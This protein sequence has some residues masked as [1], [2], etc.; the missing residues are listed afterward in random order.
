MPLFA[1]PLAPSSTTQHAESKTTRVKFSNL[2]LRKRK[3]PQATEESSGDENSSLDGDAAGPA[4]TNPLS[5]TP[6]E[7]AQYQLAGLELDEELPDVK[8]FP[9]RPVPQSFESRHKKGRRRERSNARNT[10]IDEEQIIAEEEQEEGKVERISR[11]PWL[12]NQHLSVLVTILH[13]CLGE[14]DIQRASRAWALLLRTQIS[15]RGVD[16][17][18][19]G[20]WE[21][22]AAL[23][24]RSR[25]QKKKYSYDD[26]ERDE[27]DEHVEEDMGVERRWGS[28]EGLELVK[29]YYERLILEFPYNRQFQ[30]SVSAL[31]FWPAMV[32]CEIYGVQIEQKEGLR[33]VEIQEERDNEN[34]GSGEESLDS[35]EI[36][37]EHPEED[38]FTF[39]QRRKENLSRIRAERRW[40]ERENVRQIAL[41]ASEKIAAKLDDIMTTPPYSDSHNM[42]RLRGMLALYIGDI[43]IPAL[44]LQQDEGKDSE[45]S[46]RRSQRLGELDKNTER[47]FLYRQRVAEHERGQK[48]QEAERERA[49][50]LFDRIIRDG[51]EDEDIRDSSPVK[52]RSEEEEINDE[53]QG[54]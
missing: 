2:P 37:E 51:G 44:P 49:A 43:S 3:R 12:R 35:D 10:D 11:G 54:V 38:N 25:D 19:N 24:M 45:I 39:N 18:S 47:R 33:R 27:E 23:L 50:K 4:A 40:E 36:E 29:S 6:V 42:L 48:I 7:I 53:E 14:G 46:T 16:I 28:K 22:G 20:Y 5:L 17:R 41:A 52:N 1:L 30:R 8:D 32:G 15:G 9:H 26:E 13:K 34:D 31:D 21:V